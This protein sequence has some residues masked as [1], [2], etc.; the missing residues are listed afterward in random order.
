MNLINSIANWSPRIGEQ[1][2]A[3]EMQ[4]AFKKWAPY[5]RLKFIRI[6][7][8]SADIIV[9]FGSGYHGDQQPFDGPGNTLAHAYYPYE[10]DAYGG[11]IH[12]DNDENWQTPMSKKAKIY[13]EGE[14]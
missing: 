1:N 10:M 4:K 3:D 7:E 11:D 6:F 5:G 8:P 2:V 14:S 13:S 12:F 9:G